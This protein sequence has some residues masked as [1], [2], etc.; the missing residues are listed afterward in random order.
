MAFLLP[1]PLVW[2]L[3]QPLNFQADFGITGGSSVVPPAS[4]SLNFSS[5]S[6][7]MYI[8]IMAGIG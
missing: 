3:T 6:N 8:P 7:S 5:S 2:L 4:L 1:Q